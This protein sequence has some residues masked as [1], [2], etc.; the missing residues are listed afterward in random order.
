MRSPVIP[1]MRPLTMATG[2]FT[3]PC[4][5]CNYL[6]APADLRSYPQGRGLLLRPAVA[7]HRHVHRTTTGR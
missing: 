3:G 1:G 4:E 5:G 7:Q 6:S 2:N